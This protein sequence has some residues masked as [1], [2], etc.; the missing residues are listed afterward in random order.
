MDL[1]MEMIREYQEGESIR[2]LAES[3]GVS[4]KTFYKWW[5][6]FEAAGVAGLADV[7]RAPHSHPQEMDE[8]VV[9]KIIA[10][11]QRWKWGPRKLLVKL[12][13]QEPEAAWPAASTIADLLLRRG[14]SHPRRKRVRTPPGAGPLQDVAAANEAWCADYK[15][16]FRTQDGTRCDPLTITDAHSRYL[17]RCQITPA[18][19]TAEVQAVFDAAFREYGMPE[20]I[21]T[22]NGSPFASRAPGGLSR[23]SL[24]WVKLGIV[25]E[26]SRPGTPQDNGRHERMHLTLQQDTLRPPAANPRRQ[27]ERF[28]QF[29]HMFNQERP[30]EALA[31]ATPAQHYA[32]SPRPFPR[33]IPEIEYGDEMAVRRVD[34]NG[35]LRWR[36]EHVFVSQ[37]FASERL[38][39]AALDDRYLELFFGP[40][41]LGW[42]DQRRDCFR[43]Q[44][45]LPLRRQLAQKK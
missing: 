36:G 16:W 27:Q 9:A 23:L 7:S 11:R 3:Y 4:R 17:L 1:R 43:R 41:S 10:A 6:R 45:P 15:G 28:R 25:C 30:H 5:Q 20:R 42:V 39:L 8:D 26:R 21:H 44:L 38:G 18:S 31:N 13:Q 2:A 12:Q 40:V 37:V 22:D 34:G 32:P 24:R 33:R 14:L 29:Q 19:N 35:Q